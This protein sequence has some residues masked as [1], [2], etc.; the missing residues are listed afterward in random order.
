MLSKEF[1]RRW[2][3]ELDTVQ[4]T[5]YDIRCSWGSPI[6][7][8]QRRTIM[9]GLLESIISFEKENNGYCKHDIE[10]L[11]Q[12]IDSINGFDDSDTDGRYFRDN[13]P[14]GYLNMAEEADFYE[15]EE[16]ED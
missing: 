11:Q 15:P 16:M 14:S 9:I 10:Q 7:N 4:D 2:K 5:M 12:C 13:F 6:K 3:T 8:R 1:Y